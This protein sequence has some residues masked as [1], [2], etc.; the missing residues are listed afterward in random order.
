MRILCLGNNTEDTD[1]RVKKLAQKS[2]SECH[3]LLSQLDVSA[4]NMKLKDGWYHSSV[5]DIEYGTLVEL[6]KQFDSVIM[7][8][9]PKEQY[10]HPDSF[11]STVK[12][13][14]NLSNG[15]F[16]DET[17]SEATIFF[18]N[19]VS[20]N[21]SFCIFPF[22]QLLTNQRNDGFTTVC[23]RSSTPI[24]HISK[25]T[26]WATNI[27]YV[28]IRKKMLAGDRLPAHCQT[29]YTLESRNILSA[30]RQETVEWAN[31]LNLTCVE[32]LQKIKSPVYY[33]IRP[34]NKCNLQCRMCGP[35]ASHLIGKEYK[36][37]GLISKIPP[38]HRTDFDLVDFTNLK[39]LYVA[40]GEPTIM[41][42]FYQFLDRCISEQKVDFEFLINTNGTKLSN[43][44]KSQ[45]KH[46][47]NFQFII[48]LD[49]YGS[50]NHYIRWPSDWNTIIANM[51][52]L[53]NNKYKCATNITVS[54]YNVLGLFNLLE[55]LENQFPGMLIHCSVCQS[56]GDILSPFIFPDYKLVL[57]KLLPIR[58]LRCYAND[59]LLQSFID[60]LISHYQST[61]QP[62]F[63]NLRLFFE[64]N[65]LLD[66][67]RNLRLQ[68]YIPELHTI[69]NLLT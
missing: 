16:L 11:Y 30:R 57:Q 4:N 36:T 7:L 18:E 51:H 24:T 34:S 68:E 53:K 54:L 50:L 62:D 25:I 31:R 40:G 26:D 22:I 56:N 23:C 45:L 21:N 9:Q 3:G 28:E 61:P 29:C 32:D 47:K 64:F 65:D 12:L 10:S 5:Y 49:G 33:E 14:K 59:H 67:S 8:D 52:Y 27:N 17:Y 55:F 38:D 19:L 35:G 43:K 44:F 60:G 20:T 13:V 15:K 48:S 66:Q 1:Y 63:D 2:S 58:N 37:L 6:A 69:R 39:K 46:F 41:P 42:K